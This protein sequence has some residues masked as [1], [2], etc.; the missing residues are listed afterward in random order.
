MKQLTYVMQFRGQATPV[1]E[2]GTAL[3]AKTSAP[4]CAVT[5]V[6]GP[7]GVTTKLR[8]AEGGEATFES[9]VTFTGD[10]KFHE[11]GTITFGA[12]SRLHFSTVGEGY[13]GPCADPD[14]KH[15]SVIWKIDSGEGQFEGAT[16]LITSNFFVSGSGEVTDNHFGVIFLK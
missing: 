4:S 15:G 7:E 13:I 9:E 2:Q 12:S 1:N 8:P 16:G 6:V 3:K 5:T 10:D 11:S 14:L